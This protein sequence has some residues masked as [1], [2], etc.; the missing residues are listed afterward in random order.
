MAHV[1]KAK[2]HSNKAFKITIYLW[3][4]TFIGSQHQMCSNQ[5]SIHA[6]VMISKLK[7]LDWITEMDL[8]HAFNLATTV[9]NDL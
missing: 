9:F 8:P 5:R 4:D 6:E 7:R 2:I 1:L 3:S